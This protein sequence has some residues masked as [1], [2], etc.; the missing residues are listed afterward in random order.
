MS[1]IKCPDCGKEISSHAESC[2]H[3][4]YPLKK[5][6]EIR[7]TNSIV[8]DEFDVRTFGAFFGSGLLLVGGIVTIIGGIVA[9]EGKSGQDLGFFI[10]FGIFMIILSVILFL[11]AMWRWHITH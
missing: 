10:G 6:S 5:K 11:I 7:P 1:L 8:E 4:G 9:R 2:P 3:C